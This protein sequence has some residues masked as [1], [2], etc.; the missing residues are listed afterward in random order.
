MCAVVVTAGASPPFIV[1]FDTVGGPPYHGDDRACV[2]GGLI[3]TG[4]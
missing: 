2:L 4:Y 3:S 1:N